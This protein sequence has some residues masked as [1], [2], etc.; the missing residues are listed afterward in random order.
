[1]RSPFRVAFV[2]DIEHAADFGIQTD[3]IDPLYEIDL[4]Y[5]IRNFS[6][7]DLVDRLAFD[8]FSFGANDDF[9]A[10]GIERLKNGRPCP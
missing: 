5:F 8:D 7:D 2:A 1:M 6:N 9:A 3:F 4:D 10:S